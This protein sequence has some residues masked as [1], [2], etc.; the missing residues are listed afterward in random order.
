MNYKDI[1]INH[2]L[3][4]YQNDSRTTISKGELEEYIRSVNFLEDVLSS[5]KTAILVVEYETM[6]YLFCSSSIQ[7]IC[8]YSADEFMKGGPEF[9]LNM[10]DPDHLRAYNDFLPETLEFFLGLSAEERKLYKFSFTISI[11]SKSGKI[12]IVL[13][14]NYFLKWTDNGNPLIKLM[15]LTDISDYKTNKDLVYFISRHDGQGKNEIVRQRNY[16]TAPDQT[17]SP[18]EFEILEL[19]SS[20]YRT[21][22]ISAQLKI[23]E[24]TVKN[25]RKKIL[26]KLGCNN[27]AQAVSLAAMYGFINRP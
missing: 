14:H 13:Q 23:S 11:T 7:K 8:G 19:F 26:Q 25:H 27:V 4:K 5:S 15:T 1:S 2:L 21:N 3:A 22:E 12:T 17:I 24:N 6:K 16:T 20:G 10:A 18:R 9:A